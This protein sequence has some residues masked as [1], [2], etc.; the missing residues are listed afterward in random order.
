M[1][2][3]VREKDAIVTGGMMKRSLLDD[4]PM[5]LIEEQF[6]ILC[7]TA[8]V[9]IERIISRGH[10][11]P[12]GFWYDQ[13]RNEFVLLVRGSAGLRF[14]HEDEV[15]VLEAGDYLT[16]GAHVKHRV[17]WTDPTVETIWLAVHYR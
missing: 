3:N 5:P 4:I 12:E 7:A 1:S 9:K 17:E 2:K 10:A 6:H 13:D 8:E 11:S 15:V 14:E 16:I